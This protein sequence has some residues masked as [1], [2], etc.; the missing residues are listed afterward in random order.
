MT[1][2]SKRKMTTDS[3]FTSGGDPDAL[4]SFQIRQDQ[5]N[6]IM[7][8]RGEDGLKNLKQNYNNVHGVCKCLNS[9]LIK[10]LDG[11]KEDLDKRRKA[12]G[13]NEIP[14]RPPKSFFRLMYEAV[15]D[16]ILITLIICAFI[17][18][19]LSFYHPSADTFAEDAQ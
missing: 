15:Q 4:S 8:D 12:F 2:K 14:P 17:S 5:L 16:V 10:G 6:Q 13:K 18:F 11:K 7:H 3:K 19:G 1:K 9:D